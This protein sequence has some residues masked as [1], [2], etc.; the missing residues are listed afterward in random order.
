MRVAMNRAG[1]GCKAIPET[2][3]A[4]LVHVRVRVTMYG[5]R[6]LPHGLTASQAYGGLAS[7]LL[8]EDGLRKLRSGAISCSCSRPARPVLV[9][10]GGSVP[11]RSNC[12][13]TFS[14]DQ[15]YVFH[16]HNL[17]HEELGVMIN[18]RVGG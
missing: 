5:L 13:R 7:L 6:P 10:L 17:G 3:P 8:V 4:V 16:C 2:L 1:V 12:A 15:E 14:G 11:S 9:W 18:Y